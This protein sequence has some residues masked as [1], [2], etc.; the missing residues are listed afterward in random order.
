MLTLTFLG[1]GSA[2]AKR[3][4][5]S[6]CLFEFWEKPWQ[7]DVPTKPPD[8]TLLVDFGVTG[9]MALYDLKD[10][11]GFEY[12]STPWKAINYP[13]IRKVFITHQHADHIG[14]LEEMALTNTFVFKDSKTGKPFK[15]ELISTINILVN[16]WDHSLKGG[17][18][19]I[20]NRYA[21]LQDYFFIRALIC[22]PGKNQFHVGP[23]QFEI[24]PTDHVHIERKYDWPSYGLYVC[25]Q[26]RGQSAFFSG[27]TRFDYPAY[28]Q[29][30]DKADVCFHDCQLFD[31]TDAV[32]ASLNE[33]LSL[34]EQL[35]KKTYL[36]HY[37]DN[38]EDKTWEKPMSN[39]KGFARPQIRY[40]LFQ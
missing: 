2:F 9:P 25:D 13:A 16:L 22:Q 28:M 11:P 37:G 40:K 5:N 10:K 12:L 1:V 26:Q 32:H 34:P 36:Y 6:N 35:R 30:M 15:A 21:L 31:Q 20:Q 38:F 29:M 4:Y 23:Y 14:G 27:D 17:L 3:N 7:G 19:T 24:F 8:D 39:F 33:C 18:N